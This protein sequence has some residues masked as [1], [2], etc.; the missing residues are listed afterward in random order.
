M[1]S[2][3]AMNVWVDP[4]GFLSIN[5]IP[6]PLH[7]VDNITTAYLP[8]SLDPTLSFLANLTRDPEEEPTFNTFTTFTTPANKANF[9]WREAVGD[10][11][12]LQNCNN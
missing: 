4:V 5:K 3:S 7:W 9:T 6:V 10:L 12:A 2:Y 8:P 1:S 11:A